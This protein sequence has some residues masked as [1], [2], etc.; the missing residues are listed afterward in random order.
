MIG[1]VLACRELLRDLTPLK[2]DCGRL[3][4]AACC[5]SLEGEETGMLLFPGE[6]WLYRDLPGFRLGTADGRELLFCSGRCERDL[7]PLSCRIFPLLPILREDGV[8]VVTDA[9]AAAV[10]PLAGMGKSS[11]DS[12]FV[13]N[14]RRCGELLAADEEERAFLLRLTAEHDELRALQKS[15]RGGR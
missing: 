9:R 14:V 5:S 11:L 12:A 2:A 13:E 4:G 8:R 1:T 6:A 15:F 3:C 7:R 10:C